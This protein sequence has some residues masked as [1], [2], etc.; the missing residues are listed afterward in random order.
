MYRARVASWDAQKIVYMGRICSCCGSPVI[1]RV[2]V[3]SHVAEFFFSI[4]HIT[5]ANIRTKQQSEKAAAE[6]LRS[7]DRCKRDHTAISRAPHPKDGKT[8]DS[9]QETSITGLNDLCPNCFTAEPWMPERLSQK[10]LE[11]LEE[12]NFPTAFQSAKDALQ[13]ALTQVTETAEQI[14]TARQSPE[15]ASKAQAEIQ[16]QKAAMAKLEEYRRELPLQKKKAALEQELA[17][18]EA[19]KYDIGILDIPGKRA[20]KAA[21]QSVVYHLQELEEDFAE[22]CVPIDQQLAVHRV[23]LQKAMGIADGCTGRVLL[24]QGENA[25]SFHP[26]LTGDWSLVYPNGQLPELLGCDTIPV[27]QEKRKKRFCL[28]ETD[29][30]DRIWA[31]TLLMIIFSILL[32]LCYLESLV[33]LFQ[34]GS[35]TYLPATFLM[36]VA[37]GSVDYLYLAKTNSKRK[38]YA[39]VFYL[40]LLSSMLLVISITGMVIAAQNSLQTQLIL[41]A[42]ATVAIL[43]SALMIFLKMR[44]VKITKL[45]LFTKKYADR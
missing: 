37:M 20:Y 21:K 39:G 33:H 30:R 18:L 44:G 43:L 1:S 6:M 22:A 27:L 9:L 14:Q 26:A 34:N 7:I 36:T 29:F 8:H 40:I 16:K 10:K 15:T 25:C 2:V 28:P 4:G 13:W 17:A 12:E 32:P 45:R 31:E 5:T 11:D 38:K 3:Q 24:C 35:Y 42:V 41:S 19:Q 23:L